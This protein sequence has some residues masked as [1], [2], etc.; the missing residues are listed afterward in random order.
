MVG[1]W[2]LPPVG[3]FSIA[4][5]VDRLGLVIF[6]GMGVFMSVVAELY[7]RN[8]D[9]A[10][11]YEREAALREGREALRRQAELIDPVRA[12][13]MRA[14]CSALCRE[15]G[16]AGAA[17]VGPTGEALRRVPV[18]AGAAVAG[19]GLLVLVGWI[20]GWEPLTASCRGW[21]R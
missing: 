4:S 20:F 7:R 12:E 13:V 2:I 14:K 6:A 9:K 5:A 21:P 17:A 3:Q 8:R 16:G 1:Y 15:R 18:V 11:A 10:A 19:V